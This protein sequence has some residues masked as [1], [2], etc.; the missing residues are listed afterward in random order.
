MTAQQRQHNLSLSIQQDVSTSGPMLVELHN[1]WYIYSDEAQRFVEVP[2]MPADLPQQVVKALKALKA[3]EQGRLLQF[4]SPMC[5][6]LEK[7]LNNC[8]CSDLSPKFAED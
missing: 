6:W 8:S 5:K 1:T 3:I 2:R 7:L 4:I